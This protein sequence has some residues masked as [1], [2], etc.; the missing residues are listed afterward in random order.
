MSFS[1]SVWLQWYRQIS[2]CCLN[3]LV[4]QLAVRNCGK[5]FA[6]F[7][8][9]SYGWFGSLEIRLSLQTGSLIRRCRLRRIKS[10]HRRGGIWAVWTSYLY[11]LRPVLGSG[12]LFKEVALFC[13]VSDVVEGVGVSAYFL[14]SVFNVGGG[15]FFSVLSRFLLARNF[16]YS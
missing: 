4:G 5:V 6:W 7:C 11:V 16:Y 14:V 8:L 1:S 9:Q 2:L 13:L 12:K 3:V 15:F 10:Y